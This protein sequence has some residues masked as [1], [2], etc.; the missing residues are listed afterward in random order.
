PAN[1]PLHNC[2]S[3]RLDGRS[4]VSRIGVRTKLE[5]F[6]SECMEFVVGMGRHA[7]VVVECWC[8][9]LRCL[10]LERHSLALSLSSHLSPQPR[11]L[12]VGMAAALSQSTAWRTRSRRSSVSAGRADCLTQTVIVLHLI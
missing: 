8:S 10:H 7:R 3:R 6:A 11:S 1:V 5:L 4:F 2:T 9:Q 12:N